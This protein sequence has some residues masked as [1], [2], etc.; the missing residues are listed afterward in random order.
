M[1]TTSR[2]PTPMPPPPPPPPPPGAAAPAG[3]VVGI[4]VCKE[5][6]DLARSD[7]GDR[8][9]TFANDAAGIAAVVRLLLAAPAPVAAVVIESTGG[10]ER[11][12]VEALLEAGLPVALVHPG[13]VRHFAKGLGVESKTDRIDA[14]V[15]VRFGQ[16]AAPRLAERRSRNE[17]ELR[18]LLACRRQLTVTRTQQSNRRGATASRAALKAI[19]AVIKALDRQIASLDEQVRALVDADDDFRDLARRLRSVPGV[20]PTLAATLLAD[21]RELGGAD[22]RR[23]CALAG[24]APFPD[25]SGNVRGR[26]SIR[27]GR[28]DVRCVLY[29]ATLAAM[30]FNPVIRAFA[31]RLRAAGKL[32]KVT[33]VACMRKLLTLLNAMARDGL[34]WDQLDVVKNLAPTP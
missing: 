10:L 15:L 22:R 31:Q 33:V 26:R 12:L 2:P 4:D 21:L 3:I 18:D 20:G 29:M 13:R 14:R 11:P 28:A 9:V 23:V 32:G 16:L 1:D 8:V 27:G 30:R 17:A 34:S 6:L 5:R 19:D 24:V 7:T 25:D